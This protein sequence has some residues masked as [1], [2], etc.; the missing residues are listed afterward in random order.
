[1]FKRFLKYFAITALLLGVTLSS[2]PFIIPLDNYRSILEAKLSQSVGRKVMVGEISPQIL[3]LPALTATNVSLLSSPDHPGE[4]FVKTVQA[5]L[6]PLALLKGEILISSIHLNGVGSDLAFINA[7]IQPKKTIPPVHAKS[8]LLAIHKITATNVMLRTDHHTSLG[9]YRFD[10]RLDD[11]FNCKE[12]SLSRMDN[13]L[14]AVLKPAPNNSYE[15][16]ASGSHW[17]IPVSPSL[18]FE[19]LSVKAIIQ[20]GKAELTDVKIDGYDGQL[21][22]HGTL[23]W[24]D[25]WQYDGQL[26]TTHIQMAPLLKHFDIN[27]YDGRFYSNLK[28]KLKG[29]NLGDLF[30]NPEATGSYHITHGAVKNEHSHKAWLEFDEFSANAQLTEGALI[31]ENNTLKTSGGTI[32]GITHLFWG[33]EWAI[34][35]WVVASEI[36]AEKFLSGFVDDKVTSGHFY[37]AAEFNLTASEDESLLDRPYITGDFRMTNGKIFKADL[38]KASTTLSS[39][40]SDGGETPFQRLTGKVTF[41]NNHVNVSDIDIMSD[42]IN[43]RGEIN[44][45]PQQEL[46]GEITVALRKT[47]SIISAPLKVSGSVRDPSLR[48]TNDAIIGGVIGTSVLGAGLGTAVGMKVGRIIKNIAS[49]FGRGEAKADLIPNH[50]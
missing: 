15:L 22:T 7:L 5:T 37:A 41:E 34:N 23:S 33:K 49:T 4:I 2:L 13:T 36:D 50:K 6:D 14:Q 47:A 8:T 39:K 21:T 32:Q 44:I 48:L 29:E 26:K 1:M 28:I 12:I 43:A 16:Q 35:G 11:R 40:G 25:Q 9:P 46:R 17:Y 27:R 19:T 38:E 42:S 31:N 24:G 18:K 20:R 30:I 45:N 10:L 3:P